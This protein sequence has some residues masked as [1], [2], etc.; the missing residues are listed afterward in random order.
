M[1]TKIKVIASFSWSSL[2]GVAGHGDTSLS[3]ATVTS[4]GHS[5]PHREEEMTGAN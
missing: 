5:P 2:P 4:R 3:G 1:V